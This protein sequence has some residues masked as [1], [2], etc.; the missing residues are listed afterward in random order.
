VA[1]L[2]YQVSMQTIS[3]QVQLGLLCAAC[4]G[5]SPQKKA[6]TVADRT[7]V[8]IVSGQVQVKNE[9]PVVQK[10]AGTHVVIDKVNRW[11]KN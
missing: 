4:N 6:L 3:P 1:E 5:H 11:G 8:P 2:G 10:H 9:L 7:G